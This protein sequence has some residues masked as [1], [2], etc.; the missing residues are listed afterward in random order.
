MGRYR[1]AVLILVHLIIIAHM[2]Q[3]VVSGM[4]DGIRETLSPIEPS[5]SMFTLERGTVNAGF[6]FFVLALISTAIVGRFV[7]GWGCHVVALQDWCGW[8]M[9]KLGIHPKP[10][11]SRLLMWAPLLL[12]I[13]LFVWPTLRREVIVPWIGTDLNGNGQID[14]FYKLNADGTG[15][16]EYPPWL[17]EVIPLRTFSGEFIVENFWATFPPWFV[18][19]P[20]LFVCGFAIVYFLG[21]KAFCNYGCP[22]GGFFAPLDRISPLRIRVNDKCN[23]CGHCTTVCTSNVR[24]HEEVKHFGAVV[25]PG[26]M[27]CLDCITTCPND[28]LSLGLGKPALFTS[29]RTSHAELSPVIEKTSRRYDLTV[30]EEIVFGV[31]FLISVLAYRGMFAAIPLLMAMAVAAIAT[32]FIHRLWRMIS[33]R[34]VRGPFV[35]LKR[36]GR[37]TLWGVVYAM[38][39][40]VFIAGIV[41]GLVVNFSQKRGEIR[42]AQIVV[43]REVVFAPNYTPD[44]A[45]LAKTNLAIAD[46]ERAGLASSALPGKGWSLRTGPGLSVRLAFLYAAAGR[47]GDAETMLLEGLRLNTPTDDLLGALITLMQLRGASLADMEAAL[48]KVSQMQ[49]DADAPRRQLASLRLSQNRVTE[50]LVIYAERLKAEPTDIT[51]A[52]TKSQIALSTNNLPLA[53]QTLTD[54]LKLRPQSPILQEAM[55]NVEIAAGNFEQAATLLQASIKHTP[56][57]SSL[58]TLAAIY[59][60]QNKPEQAKTLEQ[61]ARDL[62]AKQQGSQTAQ[63]STSQET[64]PHR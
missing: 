21:A 42:Y 6:V 62:Q 38:G 26:C 36:D 1:A 15:Q 43:P 10:F 55:A 7:C 56:Q 54:A 31:I 14:Y 32:F 19:V 44:P 23:Q 20:F 17:G 27:K 64:S 12:A 8:I 3:W 40:I 50:A 11:R 16:W 2:I 25:S 49:P 57:V 46:L 24:V 5:E 63:P 61:Q 30:R 34:H 51:A 22:Y 39:A 28:A 41:H 13:Y 9:K 18:S 4:R 48:V 60:R 45:L 33:D 35:Q 52:V 58:A 37:W 29:P 53:R 47:R 59:A